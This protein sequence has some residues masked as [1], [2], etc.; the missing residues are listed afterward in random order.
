MHVGLGTE[1]GHPKFPPDSL[2]LPTEYSQDNS[3]HHEATTPSRRQTPHERPI[4]VK[5]HNRTTWI[6][7]RLP[8]SSSRSPVSLAEPVRA[9][10]VVYRQ[11]VKEDREDIE[12]H[13]DCRETA[14]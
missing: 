5:P 14:G 1:H 10:S 2:S 12:A 8:S 4:T 7:L 13:G 6:P 9:L 11:A 3:Q